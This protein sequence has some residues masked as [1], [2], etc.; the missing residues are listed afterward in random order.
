MQWIGEDVRLLYVVIAFIGTIA[1]GDFTV[2][3]R[4]IHHP[5]M[6]TYTNLLLAS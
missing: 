2:A 6:V 1:M 3:S 4:Y 5:I